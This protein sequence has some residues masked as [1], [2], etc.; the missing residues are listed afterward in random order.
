M[1][2]F[3]KIFLKRKLNLSHWVGM[4]V[5]MFGLVLVGCSSIFKTQHKSTSGETI[6]GNQN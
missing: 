1:M 5:T 6:L 4:M 2:S 3:Q